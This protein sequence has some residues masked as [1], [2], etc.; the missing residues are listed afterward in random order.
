MIQQKVKQKQVLVSRE[1]DQEEN[2]NCTLSVKSGLRKRCSIPH[3]EKMLGCFKSVL[4]RTLN[5]V[6]IWG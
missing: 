4:K 3:V 5:L 1:Q 2:V 6:L